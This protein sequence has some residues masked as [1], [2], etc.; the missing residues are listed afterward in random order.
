[1]RYSAGGVFHLSR[2]ESF[3]WAPFHAVAASF[4]LVHRAGERP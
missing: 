4:R 2:Y 1:M 3:D